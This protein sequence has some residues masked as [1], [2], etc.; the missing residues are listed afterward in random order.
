MMCRMMICVLIP[1]AALPGTTLRADE[2]PNKTESRVIGSVFGKAVTA[3]DIGL[4]EPIDTS[5]VFDARDS[6]RWKLM[7]RIS[8]K[9]G[10]PVLKKFVKEHKIAATD[11][12]IERFKANSRKSTDRSVRKAEAKLEEL[13]KKLA[14]ADLSEEEK[15]RLMKEQTA[16]ERHLAVLRDGVEQEV[17]REFAESFIVAWKTE[18]ELH[19]AYGGRV[20]FQQFGPEALDARRKLFEQAEKNGD[21]KFDDAGVRHMFYY[22]ANMKHVVVDDKALERPWFFG[23]DK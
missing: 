13:M 22:Y 19:R 21:L 20:I 11:K 6:A 8:E 10:G 5:V 23:D 2:N 17:P 9:L 15:A 14:A 4:T 1:A 16:Q 7:S 12:E 3:A 18:H